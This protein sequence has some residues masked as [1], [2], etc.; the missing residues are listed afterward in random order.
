MGKSYRPRA[1]AIE[2][3]TQCL[4]NC[5][6]CGVPGISLRDESVFTKSSLRDLIRKIK[7]AEITGLRITGGDPFLSNHLHFL[8]QQAS[9]SGLEIVKINTT[10]RTRGDISPASFLKSLLDKGFAVNNVQFKSVISVGVGPQQVNPNYSMAYST[11]DIASVLKAIGEYSDLIKQEKLSSLLNIELSN[12]THNSFDV[13]KNLKNED[14][15]LFQDLMSQSHISYKKRQIL[16]AKSNNI[17]VDTSEA[18]THNRIDWSKWGNCLS[19][20]NS[21]WM[22]P[23]MFI[24]SNGSIY[25]CMGWD[26]FEKN[27]VFYLGDI[28]EMSILDAVKLADKRK[29]IQDIASGKFQELIEQLYVKSFNDESLQDVKDLNDLVCTLCQKTY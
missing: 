24:R 21:F 25:S 1:V 29:N 13:M 18:R 22:T 23:V 8:I 2:L 20:S 16:I 3:T 28:S 7:N 12:Y 17:S 5:F 27:S 26:N 14:A 4:N 11:T 9:S 19:R 15:C 10:T 6:H